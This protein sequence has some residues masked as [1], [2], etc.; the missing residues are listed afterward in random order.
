[1]SNELLASKIVTEEE[2]PQVRPIAG[3]AT[4]A[5]SFLGVAERGPIGV[6]TLVQSPAE[7]DRIFG[8]HVANGVLKSAV[9][10]FFENGGARAYVGRTV[11]YTDPTDPNT[12]TS[13]KGLRNLL[14]AAAVAVGGAVL[15]GLVGPYQL[16]PGQQ[17]TLDTDAITPTAATF[18]A[19]KASRESGAAPFALSDGATLTISLHGGGVQTISIAASEVANIGAVTAQELANI[20]NAKLIGGSAQIVNAGKVTIFDDRQGTSSGVNV[21]G[22]TANASL[23]FTT[24]NVAGTG[25]V[26]D[27]RAVTVAEAKTVIEAAVAGVLVA[28]VGGAPKVTR[29]ATGSAA[30]VQV[31]NATTATAFGFDNIVH[32]GSDAGA[33]NTLRLEGKWEGEYIAAYTYKIGNA[34]S[35]DAERFNLQVLKNGVIYES[36]PNLTMDEDDARYVPDVLAAAGVGSKVLAAVDL[37]IVGSTLA[38]RPANGTYGA[39]TG[40]ADGLAGL[41]DTDWTG[42]SGSGGK[43]GLR[44]FDVV[45]D[46]AVVTV[47]GQ[48][49]AAIANAMLTYCEIVRGKQCF[50]ILDSP[51]N[52]SAEEVVTYF[53]QTAGVLGLSEF[54]AAYWPRVTVLNPNKGVFGNEETISVPPSGHIA[55]VYARVDASKIGGVYVPPAGEVGQLLGIQGF[56][57]ADCLEEEKRDLVYPKRINPLTFLSGLGRHIDGTKTLKGNGN[58]P[59]VAERRGAI[60]I[61]QSI[62]GGLQFARHKNNTE[63]LRQRVTRTVTAFLKTQADNDAFRSKDPAKAFYVD[64]GDALNPPSV[65]FAGQLIGRI[66]LAT[67]K[68]IDFIVLRFS[69]DT[70]AL[71]QELAA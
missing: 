67:N 35:G 5:T 11:H 51:A 21:T 57:H 45:Q 42:A 53:D 18:N 6:A 66:G 55:G 19:A 30:S 47:P 48:A 68:A 17:V 69:Q 59:G 44:M 58:F 8:G 16:Q 61:E 46:L 3:V 36:F 2:E 33:V 23:G 49:T 27:I 41:T 20:V 31:T 50:A 65:Q 32:S 9:D 12:R 34:T 64:F 24:G 7:Y 38:R 39:L 1:M 26:A 71:E 4:S 40:A 43:T 10:G 62:K 14:S 29:V 37:A 25:N 15:A 54:G 22:G 60:Y 63:G 56:D 13:A 70:R 28:N 52:A